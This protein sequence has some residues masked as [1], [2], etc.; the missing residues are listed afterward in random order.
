L[1]QHLF[2]K[3]FDHESVSFNS[4]KS[5]GGQAVIEGVMMRGA[6]VAAISVRAPDGSIVTHEQ[7]LNAAL[8]RGRIS[9]T[10]FVRGMIGLWDALGLGTRALLWSADVAAGSDENLNFNGPLGWGMLAFSLLF[11]IGLFCMWPTVVASVLKRSS[12]QGLPDQQR[13]ARRRCVLARLARAPLSSLLIR[14]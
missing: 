7:A 10:P 13:T 3:A 5:Y 6:H 8:Y 14:I 11:G 9:R 4:L 1:V 2:Q 12:K